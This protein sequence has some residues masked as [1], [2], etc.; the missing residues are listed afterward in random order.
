MNGRLDKLSKFAGSKY[1]LPAIKGSSKTN[2]VA[3]PVASIGGYGISQLVQLAPIVRCMTKHNS[4]L[5]KAL[6]MPLT[7]WNCVLSYQQKNNFSENWHVLPRNYFHNR[8]LRVF[9][10][11]IFSSGNF[12]TVNFEG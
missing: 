11:G 12:A 4:I 3:Y 5:S 6:V 10:S 2:I 1:L 9:F 7:I 8:I